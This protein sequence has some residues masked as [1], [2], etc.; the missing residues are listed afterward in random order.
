MGDREPSDPRGTRAESR[1]SSDDEQ[2]QWSAG[3]ITQGPGTLCRGPA[4]HA[5]GHPFWEPLG[6]P[7]PLWARTEVAPFTCTDLL[8]V[9]FRARVG[10]GLSTVGVSLCFSTTLASLERCHQT[11]V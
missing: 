7:P 11:H 10:G 5:C 8:A 9:V 1:S 3:I 6:I 4:V 2:P